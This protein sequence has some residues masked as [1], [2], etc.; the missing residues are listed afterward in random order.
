[1]ICT[2]NYKNASKFAEVVGKIWRPADL[3]LGRGTLML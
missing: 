3:I 1:M 2:K